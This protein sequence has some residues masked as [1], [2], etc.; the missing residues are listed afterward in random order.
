MKH[1]FDDIRSRIAEPPRWWDEHGTPRWSAFTPRETADIYARTAVLLEIACQS[2]GERF[3]VAMSE[4]HPRTLYGHALP[5]LEASVR[6]GSVHY[7]DPPNVG[8]CPAG[9]TMNCDDLAVLEFWQWR[10]LEWERD[11]SL[12]RSLAGS[13]ATTGGTPD[14]E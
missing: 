11:P 4:S 10:D 6:D 9:A 7:G 1:H 13:P 14:A 2:C 5:S 8:C 3:T 12:E